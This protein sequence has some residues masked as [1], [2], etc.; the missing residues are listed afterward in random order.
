LEQKTLILEL[1]RKLYLIRTAE[2]AIRKYYHED[3]MKSPMHMSMGE[4]AI[5]VGVS[6]AIGELGQ[7]FGTYRSHALYIARTNETDQFFAEMYGKATGMAHG[8]AGSM[9]M[10][11]PDCGLLCNS[12]IVGS[13]I[14]LAVG[15]AFANKQ[16]ATGRHTA[17]FFGDGATD[18]GV[19]WESLNSAALLKIPLLFVCEDN[20]LAV[21]TPKHQRQGFHS[22]TD[23]V[24][25]FKCSVFEIDST[26]AENVFRITQ[27]AISEMS[28]TSQPVFLRCKW[29]RYLEHVGINEDFEA[30][31]RSADEYKKWLV[32]DPIALQRAKII[33]HKILTEDDLRQLECELVLQVEQSITLAKSAP[34]SEIDELYRGVFA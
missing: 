23:V 33:E 2:N 21:H 6:Q 34:F 5:V 13:T 9:H 19:F 7:V 32:R 29:Y 4:E 31:Y 20:D 24:S 16:L 12:A 17:V 15:A 30:G 26:D 27:Q 25:K 11:S 1:Y 10:S 8:K 18:T 22:I 14:P 28:E 3:D